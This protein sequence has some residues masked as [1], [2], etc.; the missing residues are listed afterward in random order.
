[1]KPVR[2]AVIGLLLVVFGAA[3]AAPAIAGASARAEKKMLRKVNAARGAHGL[4]PLRA[5]RSLGG[6][7]GRYAHWMLRADYFGH[8]PRIRASSRYSRLGENLAWHPGRSPRVRFTVRAWL[9]SPPHRALMLSSGFRWLGAGVARGRLQGRAATTW[10]LQF[11][12]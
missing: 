7:A 12:R 9:R 4:R 1:V 2:I 3:T 10:V 5:S 6:S 11:G 8:Q